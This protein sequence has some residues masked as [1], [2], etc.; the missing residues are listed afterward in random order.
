MSL[1]KN[2]TLL[3]FVFPLAGIVVLF[4]ILSTLNRNFIRDRVEDLVKE[5][6]S[7]T[8]EILKVNIEKNLE[9][10]TSPQAMLGQYKS[11][12]SIYYMALLDAE[13]NIL[14][15]VSQFE[16]YL[17]L[18]RD[19]N[20][21][22][23]PWILSSPAGKIFNQISTMRRSDGEIFYLYLGYSL[24]S[25]EE[26]LAHSRRSF[27]VLFFSILIGGAL[28]IL[29]L[30]RLQI[31]FLAKQREAESLRRDRERFREI[32]AFT[33]GV[34]HEIKNPLNSLALLCELLSRKAGPDLTE[35]ILAGKMQVQKIASIIDQ[36][37]SSLKPFNL[38]KENLDVVVLLDEALVTI[39]NLI[40]NKHI[41]TDVKKNRNS[42]ARIMGDR[43]LL[44]QALTNLLKNAAESKKEGLI[45][46]YIKSRH[47]GVE[48]HISDQG[49]GI[50]PEDRD[51]IF[52]P[53][54]STKKDGMGIGL[55]LTKKIIIAHNGHIDFFYTPGRGMTFRLFLP[56]G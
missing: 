24:K 21:E 33:S 2:R 56:G 19:R 32:S 14:D 34:A 43:V 6:L 45:S 20:P 16:G 46:I 17:P 9:E 40:E 51:K 8:A 5:Q 50:G 10:G 26:M 30:Y 28:L 39:E 31:Q 53:F 41:R 4:S 29:A 11:E 25:L 12:E 54:F 35:D 48:I 3:F 23:G 22:N 49:P 52:Q 44:T 27:Y 55:Y 13:K 38:K 1:S 36:F 47:S 37:S 15:W 42:A 7:G 18:S